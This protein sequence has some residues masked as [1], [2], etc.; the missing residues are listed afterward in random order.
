[1][2][3]LGIASQLVKK[4]DR[5]IWR[6]T[7]CGK[8]NILK[9]QQE[10]G[11]LHPQKKQ[12]LEDAIASYANYYW[13]I[14]TGKVDLLEFV[15]QKGKTREARNELR[16]L[17]IHKQNLTNLRKALKE[18]SFTSTLLGPWKSSTCSQYYCLKIS[19]GENI[20]GRT[21]RSAD[22]SSSGIK[23]GK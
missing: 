15:R 8:E 2:Q 18:H 12:K 10:I 5:T 7:I 6:L 20:H 22:W 23:K 17:S 1:M 14:P 9:Y 3:R 13:N 11:F 16:I 19:L 4:K 21:R